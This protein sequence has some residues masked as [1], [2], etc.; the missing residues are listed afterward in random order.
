MAEW[1]EREAG[2]VSRNLL[3]VNGALLLGLFCA[4]S[5]DWKYYL[6]FVLGCE[7]ISSS[8]LVSLTS[9]SQRLRIFV[10]VRGTKSL[11][12]GYQDIVQNIDKS[13]NKVVSTEIKDEYVLL[14]LEGKGLLVKAPDNSS[15]LEVAGE[16]VPTPDAVRRDLLSQL[17][18]EIA[19]RILPFTLDATDYRTQGYWALG[20]GIPLFLLSG[21]NI[22]K[23][24]RRN[25]EPQFAPIYRQLAIY[26]NTDHLSMQIGSDLQSPHT[27]YGG[28]HLTSAWLIKRSLFGS[29]ISPVD[30]IVWV[31][32][33][34]TKHSVNFIPTGKSYASVLV[35][36]HGQ[37][38]EVKL[39]NKTADE[40]LSELVVRVPWAVYGFSREIERVWKDDPRGFVVAVD[41]QRGKNE[42]GATAGS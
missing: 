30:D 18:P 21:W 23:A 38:I 39:S 28:L 5:A 40:L 12:T 2:R 8:E 4:L 24:L 10:T 25:A 37:R 35:G 9:P 16:L 31:Y 41:E 29:W 3:L 11:D 22:S 1:V 33:K 20:I 27:T 42:N 26:G 17:G 15:K 6:N 32:K 13:S 19:Q 14:M 36:R 34:V 7:S